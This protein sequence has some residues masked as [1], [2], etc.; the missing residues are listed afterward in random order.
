MDNTLEDI[1][2]DKEY[3]CQ[4]YKTFEVD[5]CKTTQY[6]DSNGVTWWSDQYRGE[7]NVL[8][9]YKGLLGKVDWLENTWVTKV[10]EVD[11]K[12][13]LTVDSLEDLSGF[14]FN[15][16]IVGE[17][18]EKRHI[19][20]IDYSSICL[21]EGLYEDYAVEGLLPCRLLEEK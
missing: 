4:K 9:L 18:T 6:T 17:L 10:N 11:G 5:I 1:F 20:S 21:Q 15:P 16:K 19:S 13:V 7:P 3:T 2:T 14:Y 12:I 8:K